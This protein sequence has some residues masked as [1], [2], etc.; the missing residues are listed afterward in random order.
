MKREAVNPVEQSRDLRYIN[1]YNDDGIQQLLSKLLFF[2]FSNHYMTNTENLLP[3]IFNLQKIYYRLLS[4]I[5]LYATSHF[6]KQLD[7]FIS[8]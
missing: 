3:Y 7:L 6:L 8:M 2:F 4:L 5:T 1:I